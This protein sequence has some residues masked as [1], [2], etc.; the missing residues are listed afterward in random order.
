M[1]KPF[2]SAAKLS[3]ASFCLFLLASCQQQPEPQPVKEQLE[4]SHVQNDAVDLTLLCQK[5]EKN[6]LD[7]NSQRT[8]FALEQINHDL[9]ICLPLQTLSQ[10]QQLLSRSNEMYQNFLHVDRTAAQQLAF[11]QYAFDMAQHPTIHQSHFE[12]LHIRDQYLLKHQG[13]AYVQLA[14]SASSAIHYQRDPDYLAK[15]FAP[16]MPEA[17]RVFIE[18]LALQ[19]VEPAFANQALL[20]EPFE[21]SRRALVWEEYIHKYPKSSY[22]K[23]AQHLLYEY[24]L[25]LFKGLKKSPVSSNYADPQDVHVSSLEEI[26]KISRLNHSELALQAKKFL[27]FLEMDSGQRLQAAGAKTGLSAWQQ[28]ELYLNLRNPVPHYKKDCFSDA[29]CLER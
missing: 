19:N 10:Q 29:I 11:E 20:I 24:K 25:F 3:F 7:I 8:T 6:M 17:E 13:Q 26:K 2:L 21:I 9:K 18:N 22:R 1:S 15:I 5:L 27:Q 23:D 12:Q 16:Y 28:L 4:S 14:D